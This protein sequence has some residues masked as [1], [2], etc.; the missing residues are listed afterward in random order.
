MHTSSQAA[1]SAALSGPSSATGPAS[2]PRSR[3][4]KSATAAATDTLPASPPAELRNVDWE[5]D[6]QAR[7]E[8]SERRAWRV[9]QG[10]LLVTVLAIGVVLA[11]GA[12]RQI[13][14]LP[15]V[16]DRT[17]GEVTVQQRL[18]VETV[19]L[20]EAMDKH[21]VAR[22]V[23]AR[24]AY[25]W[26]FLQ[27]DYNAVAR[28]STPEVFEPYGKQFDGKDGLDQKWKATQ[29]H[30]IHI[31]NVRL[32]KPAAAGQSGE[33]VVTYDKESLYLD[34]SQADALTRHVAT[35]RF[36]YRPSVLL[37]EGDRLDNPLGF[38]VTAYRSDPEINRPSKPAVAVPATSV[39][40]AA[41]GQGEQQ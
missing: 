22:F 13:V 30:R 29:E 35:V 9:A 27:Q 16:V 25:V 21:H 32:S 1:L 2:V 18:S 28:M 19:P 41:A 31:V 26:N 40:E 39:V 12:L 15:V 10:S 4:R 23:R 36:E 38:V 33:A 3:R 11:Q 17:T 7:L 6:H 14:P 8:R 24:Q 34:H 5:L 20:N 37:K